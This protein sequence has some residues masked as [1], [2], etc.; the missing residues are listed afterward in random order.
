MEGGGDLDVSIHNLEDYIE[1]TVEWCLYI[2]ITK[3]IDALR[4]GFNAVFP[5]EKL[6]PFSPSEVQVS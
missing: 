2:G 1:R 5:M 3:Q 6:A 4:D